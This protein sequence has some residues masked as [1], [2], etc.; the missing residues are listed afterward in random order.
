VGR[1]VGEREEG[2]RPECLLKQ[3]IVDC[4]EE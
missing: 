2:W 3:G 1:G 4:E